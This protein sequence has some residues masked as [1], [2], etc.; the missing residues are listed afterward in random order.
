MVVYSAVLLLSHLTVVDFVQA[1]T[2][3][4]KKGVA[5]PATAM[6]QGRKVLTF[7]SDYFAGRW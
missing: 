2:D 6:N 4:T 5:D 1:M 3:I 7:K